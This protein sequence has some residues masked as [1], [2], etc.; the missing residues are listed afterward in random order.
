MEAWVSGIVEAIRTV[1]AD[2]ASLRLQNEYYEASRHPLET[3]Q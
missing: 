3:K 2:E 1:K